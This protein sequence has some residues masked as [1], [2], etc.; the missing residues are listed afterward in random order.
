MNRFAHPVTF[1]DYPES[2]KVAVNHRL[3]KFTDAQ[4]K[5][6]KESIDFLSVNY[7]TSNYAESA[8]LANG[9]NVTYVT[10]RATTLTSMQNN[11]N[12]FFIFFTIQWLYCFIS[13]IQVLCFTAD[14]NGV[15]IGTPV[16]ILLLHL[17][18][19]PCACTYVFLCHV[20]CMPFYDYSVNGFADPIE[21][22]FHLPSGA[23]RASTIYKKKLQQSSTIHKRKWYNNFPLV[24]IIIIIFCNWSGVL[25]YHLHYI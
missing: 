25:P 10:D 4:S 17:S 9:V 1:G 6:L 23:S 24:I 5:L 2:M 20:A 12:K 22:A 14:K 11:N 18:L 7:Y 21:L 15:P 8:S 19:S 16:H 3:P 13:L